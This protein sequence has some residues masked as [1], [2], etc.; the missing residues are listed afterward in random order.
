M[1]TYPCHQRRRKIVWGSMRRSPKQHRHHGEPKQGRR[2]EHPDDE[3]GS[4]G[5]DFGTRHPPSGIDQPAHAGGHA[6][7]GG[8]KPT[9]VIGNEPFTGKFADKRGFV[10]LGKCV[11]GRSNDDLVRPAFDRRQSVQPREGKFE[12]TWL[13]SERSHGCRDRGCGRSEAGDG[14]A[15]RE[16]PDVCPLS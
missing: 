9:V 7:V 2:R 8:M 4:A 3:T 1:P 5:F 10:L 11:T 12:A 6:V 13:L 15:M 14:Q 16:P